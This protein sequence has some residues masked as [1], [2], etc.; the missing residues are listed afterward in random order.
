M[1]LGHSKP[2][3]PLGSSMEFHRPRINKNAFRRFQ[4]FLVQKRFNMP[5]RSRSLRRAGGIRLLRAAVL[6][7]NDGILSTAS[8]LLGVA[9]A[10]GTHRSILVAGIAGLASGGMSMAASE[11]V[12]VHSHADTEE[13][14]LALERTKLKQDNKGGQ[15]GFT[16]RRRESNDGRNARDLLGWSG[17]GNDRRHRLD[18][19]GN[20]VRAT[21]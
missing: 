9:A 5:E 13:A 10:H 11:N 4:K 3:T 2:I 20:Y 21:D 17:D 14:E 7:A 6:G 18:G 1:D 16:R 19:W 15:T 12:S 8:L